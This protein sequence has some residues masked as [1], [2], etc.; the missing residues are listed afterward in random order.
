NALCESLFATLECELLDRERLRTPA[1]ARRAVF[2]YIVGWYSPRRRHSALGYESPRH[3]E[4]RHAVP[5]QEVMVGEKPRAVQPSGSTIAQG[6]PISI[7]PNTGPI[8]R[9]TTRDRP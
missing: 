4:R 1:E 9:L 5:A 7:S 6:R 8:T 2:D 3:F